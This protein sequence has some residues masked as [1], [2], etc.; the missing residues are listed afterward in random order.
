[1]EQ[2][3]DDG[4]KELHKIH[5]HMFPRVVWSVTPERKSSDQPKNYLPLLET[6]VIDYEKEEED[7]SRIR[8]DP[9]ERS[10]WRRVD[11]VD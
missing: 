3:G 2:N 10:V 11:G 5:L 8:P 1:M 6:H 4:A 7:G 9:S